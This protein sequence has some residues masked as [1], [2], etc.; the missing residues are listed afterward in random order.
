VAKSSELLLPFYDLF[1]PK[2][3]ENADYHQADECPIKAQDRD[4]KKTTHRGFMCVYRNLIENLVILVY[5]RWHGRNVSEIFLK[6][7][8]W[9]LQSDGYTVY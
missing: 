1:K 5:H 7:F 4:K 8:T 2:F 9:T 3:L 6:N